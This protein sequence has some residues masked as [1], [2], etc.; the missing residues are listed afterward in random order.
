[1][2]KA[3][4]STRQPSIVAGLEAYRVQIRSPCVGGSHLIQKLL[5]STMWLLL[6]RV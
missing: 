3:A 1:M 5:R 2:T 4:L 6:V